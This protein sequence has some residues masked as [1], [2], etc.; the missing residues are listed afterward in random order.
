MKPVLTVGLLLT[1]CLSAA[2]D[3]ARKEEPSAANLLSGGLTEGKR[4][5]KHVFV[6]F[7]SPG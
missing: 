2:A 4:Q 3:N 7:G 5:N 6:L 1:M